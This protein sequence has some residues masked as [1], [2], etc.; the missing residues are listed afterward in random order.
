FLS[1]GQHTFSVRAF[2]YDGNSS[3]IASF[4]FTVDTNQPNVLI[5]SP[6]HNAIVGGT[7]QIR[8]SVTDNDLSEFLVEY[9]SGD[10]PSNGD[11]KPIDKLD[12]VIVSGLLAEWNA[13]PLLEAV[14]TI[15]LRAKDGLEHEKDYTVTVRLDK[16][17]PTA[18]LT[19]PQ[20]NSR[21]T[22][23]TEIKGLVA[24][25]HLDR[26]VLEYTTDVDPESA[27]WEQ[28]MQK[29]DLLQMQTIE[30]AI[31]RNWEIPSTISGRLYIRL[32][33]FD[34]AGN[35]TSQLASVEVPEA[36]AAKAGG[37]IGSSDGSAFLYVP[38]NSLAQ[39]TILTIN[40]VVNPSPMDGV[41]LAYQLEPSTLK[42][43]SIKPFT[44]T[45]SYRGIGLTPGKEPIIFRQVDNSDQWQR[46]GGS[47]NAE[48][49]TVSTIIN[50][51]GKYG[52][53]E[54][55]PVQADSLAQL[56]KGSLTCQPRAFSP[57]GNTF[58]TETTISFSL[59]KP[60]SATIKVYNVAGHLV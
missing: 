42:F 18:E 30:D 47:T 17:L 28:I 10:A 22:R 50:Q 39:D 59:D 43:N 8:G 52:V 53:M 44:L 51:L 29:I 1:D 15:R 16:T 49:Q 36:L 38:P 5:S 25:Q 7:V 26:Y 23:Q 3:R 56:L 13:Q 2:D 37:E 35:Q 6:T 57:K 34:A 12:Q 14:Y 40:R 54:M 9:A 19:N 11:F 48:R 21:L 27:R 20:D 60:A 45:I 55:A 41:L 4:D 32:T 46:I 58:N 33:A 31:D 24:D